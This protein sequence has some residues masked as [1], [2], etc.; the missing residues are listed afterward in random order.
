M[1]KISRSCLSLLVL[2]MLAPVAAFAQNTSFVAA[3]T[4]TISGQGQY[5]TTDTTTN[6]NTFYMWRVVAGRSYCVETQNAEFEASNVGTQL[7]VFRG[8]TTTSLGTN[9]YA[10]GLTGE[11]PNF[12]NS[13]VCYIAPASERNYVQVTRD[14]LSTTNTSAVYRI[15]V[16][17]SSLYSPWFFS[18]SGFEAFILIKNNTGTARSL[19]VTLFSPAGAILGTQTGTLPA[20]GSLNF[21]VSAAPPSGFGIAAANGGVRITG[22]MPLGSITANVTSLSFGQ[23]VSFDTPAAPRPDWAAR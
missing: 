20:N 2:T 4:L 21:Q 9:T 22:D 7:A 10:D 14:A 8:D 18:G 15:R 13:R 16:V 5:H 3:S 6:L 12:S 17:E 19:T 1:K 11:F 23:G